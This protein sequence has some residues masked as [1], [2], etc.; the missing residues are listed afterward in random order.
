MISGFRMS[1]G[2][3]MT[4]ASISPQSIAN[5]E[6]RSRLRTVMESWHDECFTVLAEGGDLQKV[7][8]GDSPNE[9]LG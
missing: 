7:R 6:D 1:E 5:D 8:W 2:A 4:G 3:W 9:Y